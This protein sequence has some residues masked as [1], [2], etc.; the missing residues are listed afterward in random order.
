MSGVHGVSRPSSRA[1]CGDQSPRADVPGVRCPTPTRAGTYAQT[2]DVRLPP[3]ALVGNRG[4]TRGRGT[5]DV[6]ARGPS[7]GGRGAPGRRLHEPRPLADAR[8]GAPHRRAV[9]GSAHREAMV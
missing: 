5:G 4:I 6:A 1:A 7:L 9:I 8:G 2:I 3:L